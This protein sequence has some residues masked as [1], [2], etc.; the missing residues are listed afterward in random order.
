VDLG[1]FASGLLRHGAVDE[2]RA[3]NEA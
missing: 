1:L 2:Y 3:Y